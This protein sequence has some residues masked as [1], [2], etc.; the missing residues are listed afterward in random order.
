MAALKDRGDTAIK[1][2]GR[3]IP[4]RDASAEVV[5][6]PRNDA[7]NNDVMPSVSNKFLNV[8]ATPFCS[9]ISKQNGLEAIS[10]HGG[11]MG[12]GSKSQIKA[13]PDGSG[14][15]NVLKKPDIIVPCPRCNSMET[16]FCYFNNYNVS[17]PRHFCR[18]CQRYWTAGGN[19]RNVPVGSGRRR[20]KQAAH[21]HH[22]LMS[23]SNNVAAPGDVS[24]AIHH[25]AHPLVPPVLPGPIE[26]NETVK[27][28]A[29][30]VPVCTSTVS[31]LNIGEQKDAHLD[32]L[33]SGDNKED[34]SCPSSGAVSD[35]SEN[36][37]PDSVDKN[38]P[39]NVP[40]YCNGVTLPHP[41]RPALVF[42]WSP[43]YNSIAFMSATQCPTAPVHG[44]EMARH[45]VP[46][47]AP[48]SMMAA[49]AICTPVV[50][51][52]LMPPPLWSYIPGW[53]GD[54]WSSPCP[55]SS[56]S[57]NKTNCPEDN[58]PMLG[59]HSREA[60]TD[61]QEEEKSENNIRVPKT[62]RIADPAEAAKSSVWNALGIK[63]DDIGMLKSL[64]PKV[65]KHDMIPESPQALQANPAAFSRSQLFQERT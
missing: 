64:E 8:N 10:R 19:I 61:L 65:P 58:S 26:E 23:C 29:P 5:T 49:P 54:V 35:H 42:P 45:V 6:M 32:S 18:N 2:F 41:H 63:P 31:I 15:E 40:G 56:V 30:E 44:P 38:K 52:P 22:A 36:Q 12:T 55:G 17:Q 51:F 53:P 14:Q 28:V 50:P 34:Q 7:N 48:P 4:L 46:S 1:L 20:S 13:E 3:T 24:G 21:Y 11:K 62:L 39:S 16:K 33:A 57:L 59:K 47:W 37:M 43:G 25:L 9:N 27:G 60:E